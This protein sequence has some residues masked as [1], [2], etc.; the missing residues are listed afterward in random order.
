MVMAMAMEPGLDLEPALAITSPESGCL[1]QKIYIRQTQ[2]GFVN[3]YAWK[4]K[5][6]SY[7][8]RIE[9]SNETGGSGLVWKNGNGDE[10][11]WRDIK[12]V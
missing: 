10:R 4:I 7:A 8:Q 6:F 2:M 11:K 9:S 5:Q 1:R 3:L 12:S